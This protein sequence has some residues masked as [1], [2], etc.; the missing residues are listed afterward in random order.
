MARSR[1]HIKRHFHRLRSNW[2]PCSL[3]VEK[4][5]LLAFLAIER[6]RKKPWVTVDV[7]LAT[8]SNGVFRRFTLVYIGYSP[9][10]SAN[11]KDQRPRICV[12]ILPGDTIWIFDSRSPFLFDVAFFDSQVYSISLSVDDGLC[13]RLLQPVSYIFDAPICI[14]NDLA[15]SRSQY[16][17]RYYSSR[18]CV[19]R[20]VVFLPPLLD[21]LEYFVAQL[22][23][24]RAIR[25]N[26][27]PRYRITW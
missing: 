26:C 7:S 11:S 20:Y 3:G 2:L 9:Q 13:I 16:R 25:G 14:F 15:G 24:S 10:L 8:K 4:L 18:V 5:I 21:S 6:G 23:H 22:V 1:E 19:I 17:A 27:T 12:S